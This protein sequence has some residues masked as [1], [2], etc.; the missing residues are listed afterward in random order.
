MS[1][2]ACE[3]FSLRH[4]KFALPVQQPIADNFQT[5]MGLRRDLL[6]LQDLLKT[7]NYQAILKK[8]WDLGSEYEFGSH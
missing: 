8:I 6:C 5:P 4:V 2:S 3:N 7:N 1:I